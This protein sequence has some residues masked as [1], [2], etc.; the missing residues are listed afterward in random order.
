ML[1]QL[2]EQLRTK[3]LQL[4]QCMKIVGYLRRLDLY[5]QTE[6]E[7]LFLRSR[8]AWLQSLVDA[9]PN[10][11]TYTSLTK[12]ID[13]SRKNIFD[14]VIQYKSIFSDT[15]EELIND[16]GIL[17]S[18]VGQ[19]VSEFI[20]IISYNINNIDDGRSIYNLL[21]QCMWYGSSLGKLG[22]DFR[23]KYYI[24]YIDVSLS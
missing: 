17:S 11:N 24:D 16:G 22:I 15:Q 2:H 19:N 14:I 23:G 18:W 1:R 6:L 5:S 7:L 20:K 9:V 4:P 21:D 3:E 12:R 13:I 8:G 10:D